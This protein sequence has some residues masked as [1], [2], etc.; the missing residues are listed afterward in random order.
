MLLPHFLTHKHIIFLPVCPQ[1]FIKILKKSIVARNHFHEDRRDRYLQ[2]RR[3]CVI[4]CQKGARETENR[5]LNAAEDYIRRLFAEE[6][7]GHDAFHTL[8]VCRTALRLAEEEG[9]DPLITGLAALL[10]DADDRK[11][12]PETCETNANARRFLTEQGVD[13]RTAEAVVTAI[14]EVSFRG[15]DSVVPSTL[16][17]K[18]VQDADRLDAIGA[19][20]AARAFAYGGAHQRVMH[21]P[22]VPP[23]TSMDAARYYAHNATTVN[24]FYEKLLLLKDMM[25]TAAGRRLAEARDRYLRDFL[26][27]FLAE[28]EGK[29]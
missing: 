25:N 8:R 5:L 27:E 12:S 22:A 4:L 26:E 15:T 18:C 21:D 11:L 28:W 13:A 17:G 7:S 10:H 24:H 6:Y 14:G 1:F 29:R 3:G 9:A 19:I 23:E 16:E 20:G 2:Q